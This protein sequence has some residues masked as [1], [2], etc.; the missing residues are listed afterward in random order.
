MAE[1]LIRMGDKEE[2][3]HTKPDEPGYFKGDI[4][5]IKPDGFKWGIMELDPAAFKI[6][7]IPDKSVEHLR[8]YIDSWTEED[9]NK[10]EIKIKSLSRW[11]YDEKDHTLVDKSNNGAKRRIDTPSEL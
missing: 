6:I 5:D 9:T 10:K 3:D 7:K 8:K 11:K 2:K 4:V 1:M